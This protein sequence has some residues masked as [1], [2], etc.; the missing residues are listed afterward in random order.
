MVLPFQYRHRVLL[1]LEISS[2]G[3]LH[4]M[5]DINFIFSNP[6]LTS[7]TS[8]EIVEKKERLKLDAK[9]WEILIDSP[10]KLYCTVTS[11]SLDLSV[12]SLYLISHKFFPGICRQSLSFIFSQ[13]IFRWQLR[14]VQSWL[15]KKCLHGIY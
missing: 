2:K 1:P 9:F 10:D 4:N 14:R 5:N 11:V 7:Q 3:F 12:T 13:Y 15:Q 8:K 6:V